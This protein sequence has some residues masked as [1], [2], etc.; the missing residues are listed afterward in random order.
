MSLPRPM[1]AALLLTP[2][3][4]RREY[5]SDLE[6]HWTE[7]IADDNANLVREVTSVIG[8]AWVLRWRAVRRST[9]ASV[10]LIALSGV[11]L[12]LVALLPASQWASTRVTG[13]PG[14]Y[15]GP[16][17]ELRVLAVSVATAGAVLSF[18]SAWSWPR[19]ARVLA[20][21]GATA[22]FQLVLW[23]AARTH[24]PVGIDDSDWA[25]NAQ[26]GGRLVLCVAL[27]GLAVLLATRRS[28]TTQNGLGGVAIAIVSAV[29]SLAAMHPAWRSTLPALRLGSIGPA[30]PIAL[31]ALLFASLAVFLNTPRTRTLAS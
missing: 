18:G 13:Q 24:R 28:Q 27:A 31:V 26:N 20:A 4:F 19:R 23:A 1:R 30:L 10:A 15:A 8:L 22:G 29:S 17:P 16:G 7:L 9:H 12:L 5:R 21:A 2:R 14:G 3:S 11:A 6:E 25:F